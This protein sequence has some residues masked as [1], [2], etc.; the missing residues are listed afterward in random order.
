MASVVDECKCIIGGMVLDRDKPKYWEE[1]PPQ[2]RTVDNNVQHNGY[3]KVTK[4][5]AGRPTITAMFLFVHDS[6]W[7]RSPRSSISEGHL[8]LFSRLK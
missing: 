6:T 3:S 1:N 8:E 5:W 4:L 2:R 7:V